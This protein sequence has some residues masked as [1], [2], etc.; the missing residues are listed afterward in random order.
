MILPFIVKFFQW[1]WSFISPKAEEASEDKKDQPTVQTQVGDAN[2]SQTTRSSDDDDSVVV[3]KPAS[4]A[5]SR[6]QAAAAGGR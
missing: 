2:E 5:A 4:E 6:K 1:I 3:S